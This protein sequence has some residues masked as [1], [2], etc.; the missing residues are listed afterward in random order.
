L[1]PNIVVKDLNCS[2]L[3]TGKFKY[4]VKD[5]GINTSV[6]RTDSLHIE[7]KLNSGVVFTHK[8]NW[9]SDCIYTLRL[10]KMLK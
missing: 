2:D 5:L 3:K 9:V 7:T 6:V 4:E 8:V 10:Q 1:E